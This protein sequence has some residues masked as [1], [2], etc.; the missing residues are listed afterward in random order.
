MEVGAVAIV[1]ALIILAILIRSESL[2]VISYQP[3]HTFVMLAVL[4]HVGSTRKPVV[5]VFVQAVVMGYLEMD[6]S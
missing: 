3:C 6:Q 1:R 5:T 2:E 4:E